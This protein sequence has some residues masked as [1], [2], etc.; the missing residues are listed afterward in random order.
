[1]NKKLRSYV[2][3]KYKLDDQL[4]IGIKV[5]LVLWGLTLLASWTW[6]VIL[7]IP[8]AFPL[9]QKLAK[10]DLTNTIIES[11]W[12]GN[13]GTRASSA[14]INFKLMGVFMP[15]NAKGGFAILKMSD[16]KQRVVF[17]KDEIVPGIK[18]QSLGINYIEVD[19]AGTSKK[20]FLENRMSFKASS[21]STQLK[22]P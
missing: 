19:Q 16:G 2:N 7:P 6:K 20:I 17:L 5:L 11:R 4:I 10:N 22:N 18:F 14:T 9:E 3:F 15:T 21:N 8:T 1:M 13:N 12:F